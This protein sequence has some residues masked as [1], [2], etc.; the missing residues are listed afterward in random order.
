MS[1]RLPRRIRRILMALHYAQRPL[2]GAELCHATCHGTGIVY[3][4]LDRLEAAGWIERQP[5][6]NAVP[7]YRLTAKGRQAAGLP[8]A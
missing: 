5:W 3:L 1:A 6:A 7:A 2:T 8:A 4:A